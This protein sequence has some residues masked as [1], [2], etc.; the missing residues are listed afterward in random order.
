MGSALCR[1]PLDLPNLNFGCHWG[2]FW[3]PWGPFWWPGTSPGDPNGT[4]RGQRLIFD[5][6]WMPFGTSWGGHVGSNFGIFPGKGVGL[7]FSLCFRA[8]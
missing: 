1:Q 2:S 8:L 3:Y 5:G 6:F 4:L 7:G